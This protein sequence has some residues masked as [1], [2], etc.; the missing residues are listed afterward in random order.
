MQKNV[1]VIQATTKHNNNK[2]TC[3]PYLE[4]KA[5]TIASAGGSL[6]YPVPCI[7]VEVA[8]ILN[9]ISINLLF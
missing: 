4:S 3:E 8:S 7:L 5:N 1:N 6:F 2:N 9:F